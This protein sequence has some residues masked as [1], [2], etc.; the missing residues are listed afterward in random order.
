MSKFTIENCEI[1]KETSKAIL[2]ESENL[3]EETWIPQSQVHDDSEI[4]K[5]GQ[6]GDLIISEWMAKKIGLI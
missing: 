4:W 1:I 3:D 5:E 6:K 2:V